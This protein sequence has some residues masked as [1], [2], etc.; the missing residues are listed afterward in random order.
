MLYGRAVI[1]LDH[2]ATTPLDP[3]VR[4]AM[5]ELLARD[6]LGNPSSR[7]RRGQ[8]A[9]EVVEAARRRVAQAL[10]AEALGVTF[11]SG[12]TEADD[13]AVLGVAR[14]LRAPTPVCFQ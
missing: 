8:A 13:L 14:A 3:R 5:V 6:D 2:N 12:G 10:G 7:H 4:E 11:T 1:D 9:R